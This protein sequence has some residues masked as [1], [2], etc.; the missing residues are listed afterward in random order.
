M[1]LGEQP[2]RQ[3]TPPVRNT[4]QRLEHT[5]KRLRPRITILGGSAIGLIAGAAV[6]S[7]V[8]TGA[9]ASSAP[10]SVR[11]PQ[12]A[13]AAVPA[14]PAPCAAGAKLEAGVCVVHVQRVVVRPAQPSIRA[15]A[16]VIRQSQSQNNRPATD[17]RSGPSSSSNQATAVTSHKE[18]E[19]KTTEAEPEARD[20]AADGAEHK[21]DAA[22][23]G[24]EHAVEND[25]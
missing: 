11:S 12:V 3:G 24:V 21:A 1:T 2:C 4:F 9:V 17:H 14:N 22:K 23:S 8:A 5:M 20:H 7:V 19:H 15:E 18:T 25:G 10:V 6:Y 16:P 13:V